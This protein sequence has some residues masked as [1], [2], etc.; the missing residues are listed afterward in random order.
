MLERTP[1]SLEFQRRASTLKSNVLSAGE[2]AGRKQEDAAPILDRLNDADEAVV[3]HYVESLVAVAEIARDSRCILSMVQAG[4]SESL[5]TR[6]W[7]L[8][9]RSDRI[10]EEPTSL[11]L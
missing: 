10:S 4:A 1:L 6:V 7:D 3:G 11:E 2:L 8:M 9:E 5:I